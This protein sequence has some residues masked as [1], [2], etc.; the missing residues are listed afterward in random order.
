MVKKDFIVYRITNKTTKKFYIGSTNVSKNHVFATRLACGYYG[1]MKD[2]IL[3]TIPEEEHDRISVCSK[4]GRIGFKIKEFYEQKYYSFEILTE[5][6]DLTLKE[7]H[8]IEQEYITKLKPELN[9]KRASLGIDIR[10]KDDLDAYYQQYR[11]KYRNELR[12]YNREYMKKWRKEHEGYF[13]RYNKKKPNGLK[14]HNAYKC[15][16]DN[17]EFGCIKEAYNYAIENGLFDKGYVTFKNMI[18]KQMKK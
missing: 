11:N 10:L 17:K 18:K 16:Y 13:K 7:A 8:E 3:N 1:H 2:D 9:V 14:Y 5:I 4:Q 15:V 12:D 6:H